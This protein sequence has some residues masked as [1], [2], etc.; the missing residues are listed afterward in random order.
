MVCLLNITFID[1]IVKEVDCL[2]NITF[3]DLIVKEVDMS[4]KQT[5]LL[6][7]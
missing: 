2:L 4:T 3:I 1:L 7:M 6:L 5:S